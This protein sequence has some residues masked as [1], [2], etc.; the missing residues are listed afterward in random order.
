MHHTRVIL[1]S[2]YRYIGYLLHTRVI[3]VSIYRYI[4]YL[5]RYVK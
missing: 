4:G 1:V 3:L 2:I 5:L